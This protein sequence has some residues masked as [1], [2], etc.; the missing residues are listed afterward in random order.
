M[1]ILLG[2]L[3][4]VIGLVGYFVGFLTVPLIIA[5]TTKL[6]KAKINIVVIVNTIVV[7]IL[8]QL[9]NPYL[10]TNIVTGLIS[11]F[12]ARHIMVSKCLKTNQA[13]TADEIPEIITPQ[14]QT[15]QPP[16]ETTP[17]HAPI[18]TN[19]VE[20]APQKEI[21]EE[22][23]AVKYCSR[24][25]SQIDPIS[26]KCSGCGKQYFKGISWKPLLIGLLIFGLIV[27]IVLNV[28]LFVKLQKKPTYIV[29]DN[30][31][32]FYSWLDRQEMQEKAD[33]MDDYIV[34]IEDDNTNL[35]HKF[36]CS[37]F[38]GNSFLAFNS[39]AAISEGFK[40]CPQCI[41]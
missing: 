15:P 25:G 7:F 33:F 11:A 29:Q 10:T 19:N 40:P 24:C 3:L 30:D 39:E 38:K 18:S 1:D 35:Y 5:S 8:F 37:R 12:I 4:F 36:G 32:D 6:T 14:E 21:T 41:N 13:D 20:N 28:V 16:V 23:P 34:L 9:W 2:I 22:K 26:K 31:E 17:E 27:S